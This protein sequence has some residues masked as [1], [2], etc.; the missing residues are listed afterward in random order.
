MVTK[1]FACVAAAALLLPQAA[2]GQDGEVAKQPAASEWKS[3]G[4]LP[5]PP[6][7]YLETIPWLT[8]QA[9]SQRQKAYQ[10]RGPDLDTL[11]LAT[12]NEA[13]LITRYSSM[14]GGTAPHDARKR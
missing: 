9:D 5:L 3:A 6:I 7:P 10:L 12:G 4:G 8:A 13:P 11:K 14:R 1:L 2:F